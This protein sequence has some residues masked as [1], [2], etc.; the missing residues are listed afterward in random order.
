MA[1]LVALKALN[2]KRWAAAKLTRGPEFVKPANKAVAN[3]AT[4]LEI[5]DRCGMPTISWV[6]VAVT[7]MRESSQDFSRSLA[8]G[9]PWNEVSVRIPAGRGPFKSFADAAVDALVNCAPRAARLTDW[10]IDGMLT[11]LERYNGLGYANKK[12]PSP[13]IW[14]GTDQYRKG[15]YIRD[16]VF[17]ANT[18]DEQLGCAGMILAMMVIDGSIVFDLDAPVISSGKFQV[19]YDADW[20][21]RSLN[22]LGW[23]PA[24]KEDGIA[25]PET[26]K[27]TRAFQTEHKLKVDGI[28]GT[29]Q[30]IPAIV[31]EL[32]KRGLPNE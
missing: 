12:I 32:K 22:R 29:V 3:K 26:R 1:D 18:V 27:A 20:L 2:S 16:G 9:D 13:Y 6:F 7:H 15:K 4:Y 31:A 10:S 14:S 23:K 25:G 19:V 5:V 8:Q 30:T 17:D 11:N 24:L 21:Q 28:A